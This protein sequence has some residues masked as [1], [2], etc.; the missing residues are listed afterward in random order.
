MVAYWNTTLV[1]FYFGIL[2][3]LQILEKLQLKDAYFD[4]VKSFFSDTLVPRHMQ[5]L[6]SESTGEGR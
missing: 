4:T 2:L 1:V 6:D 5:L 3:I